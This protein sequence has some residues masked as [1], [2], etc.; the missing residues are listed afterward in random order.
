MKLLNF[1]FILLVVIAIA[2]YLIYKELEFL[3]IKIN[4]LLI[5]INNKSNDV[6]IDDDYDSYK[7]NLKYN[8]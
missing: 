8:I 6:D 3:N 7:N 4:N 1:K 2:I 5:R